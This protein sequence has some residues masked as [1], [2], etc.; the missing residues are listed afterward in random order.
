MIPCRLPPK[1]RSVSE[2]L[3]I[4][5]FRLRFN[6]RE[7]W[8]LVG[9]ANRSMVEAVLGE[10]KGALLAAKMNFQANIDW[11]S[12]VILEYEETRPYVGMRF[13]ANSHQGFDWIYSN[14]LRDWFFDLQKADS[15]DE[16]SSQG[17]AGP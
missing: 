7:S 1:V 9:P 15:E 6:E 4:G 5:Q 8:I 12:P 3:H 13:P 2:D 14:Y 10:W 16:S 11:D 17:S